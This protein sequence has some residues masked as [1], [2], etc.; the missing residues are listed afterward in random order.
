[1]A[2]ERMW[3]IALLWMTIGSGIAGPST[4][5]AVPFAG[6][7]GMFPGAG[8]LSGVEYPSDG[9]AGIRPV[10]TC[11]DHPHAFPIRG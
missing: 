3:P 4:L 7:P 8:G 11:G 9:E 10:Q 5:V 6:E 1:M 2:Y